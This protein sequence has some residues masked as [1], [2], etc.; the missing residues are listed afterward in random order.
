M[1]QD[2]SWSNH[3]GLTVPTYGIYSTSCEEPVTA[4][5][6]AMIVNDLFTFGPDQGQERAESHKLCVHVSRTCKPPCT[7]SDGAEGLVPQ[8]LAAPPQRGESDMNSPIQELDVPTLPG[9]YRVSDGACRSVSHQ[10]S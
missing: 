6:E 1:P 9:E 4:G 8:W 7:E 3:S 2:W 10:S 5:E